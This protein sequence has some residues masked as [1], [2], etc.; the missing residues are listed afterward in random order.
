MHIN[1]QN[2]T[3]VTTVRHLPLA[4]NIIVLD[5]DGKAIEQGTFDALR[6][7][8]GFVGRLTLHPEILGVDPG[9]RETEDSSSVKAPPTAPK[10][11]LGPSANDMAD[12]TRQTGDVS[13][14]KYYLKSIGWKIGLANA[15]GSLVYMFGSKFPCKYCRFG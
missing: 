8:D 1:I 6:A 5:K 12:L 13:V 4:D 3:D 11:L 15:M 10:V 14:Y 7:R 9:S 2:T